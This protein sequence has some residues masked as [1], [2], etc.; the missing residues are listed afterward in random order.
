MPS[1]KAQRTLIVL[2]LAVLALALYLPT[3]C[4]VITWA[5]AGDD[6]AELETAGRTLGVAHPSGYPLLM[7]LVR[8]TA[9]FLPPPAS[10]LNLIT[11]LAAAA[12]VVAAGLAA[13]ELIARTGGTDAL[14]AV[15]G[16]ILAGAV[17]AASLTFWRQAVIGEVY[18]LHLALAA[19]ILALVLEGGPR[20]GVL[21]AWLAGLGLAHHLQMVP[22]L[23]VIA[24]YLLL[25]GRLR[26]RPVHAA[27]LL[28]P[29]SLYLVPVL[30]ARQSPAMNW[31]DP[32]GLRGLWWMVSGAP[33][34]GN[35]LRGG[36]EPFWARFRDAVVHGPAE[37]LGW[38][39][40]LL[41]GAGFLVLLRK[42][43]REAA[44]LAA[45][46]L[47]ATAVASAYAIPDPAAYHLPAILA[48]AL[49]AGVGGAKVVQS[50]LRASRGAGPWRL[51]PP[52]AAWGLVV[53]VAAA[54]V[55]RTAPRADVHADRAALDYAR[56]GM[57]ALEPDAVVVA[58]GDGRTF[59]LW[60]GAVVLTP[61]PD[62]VVLYDNLMDWTWYRT[63][64]RA[65]HPRLPLPPTGLSRPV[66]RGA[67]FE[68]FLDER[69]VYATELEPELCHLFT[70]VPAGPLFRIRRLPR[71]ESAATAA[72]SSD[73]WSRGSP[74]P[75]AR[76]AA[77][78]PAPSSR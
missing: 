18:P 67:L 35:L 1:V 64:L 16:G 33:Y 20:A 68:R 3:R 66:L 21:A 69:P 26:P 60:Y 51:A 7:L 61:R 17:L 70:A 62:V 9:L 28:A 11:M 76:P 54:G 57:A 78:P 71:E 49:A 8:T 43:P 31:G 6:G 46:F 41:A 34:R 45:L 77:A 53:A 12:A 72:A 37:Q 25:R 55:V 10:A 48:L 38:G 40:A 23:A 56:E 39:G 24:F 58:H 29:L 73:R 59:A 14:P 32:E 36:L 22:C 5:H 2:A 50:G 15:S 47:G 42:A 27:A 19:G 30:R 74:P 63:Q 75:P 52:A 13:R 65:R 4:P 44:A